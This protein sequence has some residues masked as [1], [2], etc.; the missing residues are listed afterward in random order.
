MAFSSVIPIFSKLTFN[1]LI[2]IL[3]KKIEKHKSCFEFASKYYQNSFYAFLELC[4]YYKYS[5]LSEKYK[6]SV[7]KLDD[8]SR[9]LIS[10]TSS[11]SL[12][13]SA[14]STSSDSTDSSLLSSS[15][16]RAFTSLYL[17]TYL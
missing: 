2:F 3:H 15:K 12:T 16:P 14:S 4:K 17:Q 9:T 8:M 7:K 13:S 5:E 1:E 6:Q 11:D 10:L